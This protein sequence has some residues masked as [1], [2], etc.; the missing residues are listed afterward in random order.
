MHFWE[1][2]VSQPIKIDLDYCH[3]LKMNITMW[4]CGADSTG[5]CNENSEY[6]Y[7]VMECERFHIDES[8]P[9]AMFS[10]AM[11]RGSKCGAEAVIQWKLN[12]KK[13]IHFYSRLYWLLYFL[14]YI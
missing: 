13:R 6:F 1:H 5:Q 12:I 7:E 10:Q 11:S 14:G 2:F 3:Y 9:W 8:G 4:R